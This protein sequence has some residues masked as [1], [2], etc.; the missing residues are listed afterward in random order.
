VFDISNN[1]ESTNISNSNSI[2][3][4]TQFM[5]N[6]LILLEYISIIIIIDINNYIVNPSKSAARHVALICVISHFS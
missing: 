4:C 1:L 5:L 3:N 2:L 6:I